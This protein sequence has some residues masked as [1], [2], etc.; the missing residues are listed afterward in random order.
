MTDRT[1]ILAALD[2]AI[3]EGL[4]DCDGGRVIP[5][6]E[7]FD[8]LFAELA[9]LAALAEDPSSAEDDLAPE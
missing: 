3:A 8:R 2:R 5:M 9:V 1:E 7:A 4:A 6:D